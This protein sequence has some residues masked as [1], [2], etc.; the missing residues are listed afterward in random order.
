M[1]PNSKAGSYYKV[2]PFKKSCYI[3]PVSCGLAMI[4]SHFIILGTN[5]TDP[6]DNATPGWIVATVGVYISHDP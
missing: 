2:V 4:L 5:K 3:L 6:Y 1:G